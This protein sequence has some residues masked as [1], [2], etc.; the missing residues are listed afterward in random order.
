MWAVRTIG[1][2]WA[3]SQKVTTEICHMFHDVQVISSLNI[4]IVML[5]RRRNSTIRVLQYNRYSGT[6]GR[7]RYVDLHPL[8]PVA[9]SRSAHYVYI[10]MKRDRFLE[11]LIFI[12]GILLTNTS[13][14]IEATNRTGYRRRLRIRHGGATS[15]GFLATDVLAKKISRVKD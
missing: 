8:F 14:L 1:Q 3:R 7:L 15:R 12:L 11:E 9:L 13:C 5:Y 2:N 10:I 6:L 4:S